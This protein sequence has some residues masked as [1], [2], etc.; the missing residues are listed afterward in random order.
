MHMAKTIWRDATIG[1]DY[2]WVRGTFRHTLAV[3]L[4]ALA[5]RREGP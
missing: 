4:E 3:A 1:W 5:M 2:T